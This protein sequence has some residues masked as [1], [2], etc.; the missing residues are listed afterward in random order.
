MLRIAV[1]SAKASTDSSR[2]VDVKVNVLLGVDH[3]QEQ[4]LHHHGVGNRVVNFCTDENHAVQQQTGIDVVCA[5]GAAALL[6]DGGDV[7]V[8]LGG[9]HAII[10]E[11]TTFNEFFEYLARPFVGL[12]V[13]LF[14]L[15]LLVVFAFHF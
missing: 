3:L 11:G 10:L 8:V 12:P 15:A 5:L 4:Q 1:S 2:R 9:F 14:L 6:D 7:L 13:A